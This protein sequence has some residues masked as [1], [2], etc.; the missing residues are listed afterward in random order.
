VAD[1]YHEII[2][3]DCLEVMKWLPDK[4]VD[5]V[6][7][8]LP[9]GT[10]ACAWDT[11]IA[12][13]QLWAVYRHIIRTNCAVVLTSSQPFTTD[14]IMSNREWFK[15]CWVWAK[16]VSGDVFNAKNK[17]LKKHEDIVVFSEGTTAN[18][19]IRKMPYYPQGLTAIKKVVK[20]LETI[21]AFFAPRPS[22][23]DSYTQT[24]TGYPSSIL[25]FPNDKGLHPTQ[26]PVALWEYLIRTYTNPGDTVLDNCCGSGTTGVACYNTGR[27]SIQIDISQEY[28]DIARKRLAE[29]QQLQQPTV[30]KG[31]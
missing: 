16:T 11:V 2:C 3:G 4:S 6:L 22:H 12:F 17:P 29:V 9:Y 25:Y 18:C 7:C 8:D 20:N 10:T 23:Q 26:K 13:D 30:N 5:M 31:E 21:R 14:L 15:Y 19:S 24:A 1:T 27:N 28:C